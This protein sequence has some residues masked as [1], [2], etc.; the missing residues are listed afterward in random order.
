[1][2]QLPTLSI[3]KGLL[4]E[5]APVSRGLG[6][7]TSFASRV[8]RPTAV[9]HAFTGLPLLSMTIGGGIVPSLTHSR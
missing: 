3:Q 5:V 4:S 6:G 2:T 9:T 7:E 1:V 8:R